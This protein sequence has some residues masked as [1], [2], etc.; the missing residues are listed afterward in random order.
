M[1]IEWIVERCNEVL[2]GFNNKQASVSSLTIQELEQNLDEATKHGVLP[3]VIKY[4]E[5][6]KIEEDSLRQVVI[7]WYG[8][9]Q[10]F[11]QAYQVRLLAMREMAEVFAKEKLDVMFFKGA[12][13][14]Q[15]YPD[16]V[17]RVFSDID[18]YLYGKY[19]EG[20]EA[21]KRYG[22]EFDSCPNLHTTAFLHGV[23]LENHFDFLNRW[24]HKQ[25][26]LLDDELKKMAEE[27]GRTIKAS[28]LGEGI[29][30][31]YVM[32]PTMNAV[33]LIRHM[34]LHFAVE[35]ISLRMLY[36]WI[37]FLKHQAKEVDWHRVEKLYEA[38][39][40]TEFV[41]IVQGLLLSHFG[42]EVPE[43][44]IKPLTGKKTER[45]WESIQCTPD[46][47]P[48]AQKKNMA[49][50]LSKPKVFLDNRWKHK[51]VFPG[52]SH[53]RL[54]MLYTWSLLKQKQ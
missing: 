14:A 37:L 4:L 46:V 13:L 12:A 39:G 27:E 22:I 23:L 8:K 38:S 36:D 33:F 19:E 29:D 50:Y 10:M 28:F 21:L 32:T 42:V 25:N 7:K 44:P 30:N 26:L 31:A 43:C 54:F 40:M 9:A 41:G 17:C 1:Q 53:F 5:K 24:N 16:P 6:K 20:L 18:F 47:K 52:E 3:I 11:R 34:A 49:Y 35:T 51:I 48:E 2:L 45:V 15:I